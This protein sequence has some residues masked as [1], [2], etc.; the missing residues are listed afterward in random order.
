ML[1]TEGD[2]YRLFTRR[3]AILGGLQG[4]LTAGLVGRM[5]YLSVVQ[6]QQYRVL[7]DENRLSL[8]F[9]APLRGRIVDRFGEELATNRQ[10]LRVAIIP[11][12]VDRVEDALHALKEIIPISEGEFHL[13]LQLAK[14]QRSFIPVVV[15]DNLSW[16]EFSKVNV[17]SPDLPGI[18]TLAGASRYYP[19]S[20]AFAHVLGHVGAVSAEEQGLSLIHI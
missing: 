9:I 8:R 17:K 18:Q 13:A 10:D 14:R 3:A 16:D 6:G 19:D 2:R 20:V 1:E 12:Q 15:K 5:Y 11:E 7:A 4:L